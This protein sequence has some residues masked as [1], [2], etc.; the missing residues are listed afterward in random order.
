MP[1]L[2]YA[3]DSCFRGDGPPKATRPTARVE[4]AAQPVRFA[5]RNVEEL[6]SRAHGE[7]RERG[8]RG[9]LLTAP[10]IFC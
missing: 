7:Q 1:E 2:A 3:Y 8:E 10:F 9:T 4:N 6:Y 5:Q